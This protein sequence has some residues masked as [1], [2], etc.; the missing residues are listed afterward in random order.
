[1]VA[2]CAAYEI[3][4]RDFM[5]QT[6]DAQRHH[7][8]DIRQLRNHKFSFADL[9]QILGQR[10]TLG[11][12]I[13]SS[14]TFHGTEVIN[15]VCQAVFGLDLFAKIAKKRFQITIVEPKTEADAHPSYMTGVNILRHRTAIDRCFAIRH[16]TVHNT[17][18]RFRL[19]QRALHGLQGA[20]MTFNFLV[21]WIFEGQ[22]EKP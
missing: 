8:I 4:W 6:I 7:N 13:S 18:T 10:L 5:K 17:G 16:E 14:Y 15:E 21:S 22:I 19:S 12:L 1:M 3:Y 20:M 2:L 11:E 9:H